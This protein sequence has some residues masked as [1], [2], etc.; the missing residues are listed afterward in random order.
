MSRVPAKQ[1]E[2][3]KKLKAW[4][5]KEVRDAFDGDLDDLDTNGVNAWEQLDVYGELYAKAA[6]RFRGCNPEL[7]TELQ[8]TAE[9]LQLAHEKIMRADK[10][11]DVFAKANGNMH[12]VHEEEEEEE[13]EE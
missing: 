2:P 8:E 10:S 5:V 4:T 12:A 7:A 3:A 9:S 1:E 11:L 6:R 13:E